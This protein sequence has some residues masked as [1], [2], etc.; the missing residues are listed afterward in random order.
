MDGKSVDKE[1]EAQT[2]DCSKGKDQNAAFLLAKL[3]S[4]DVAAFFF[5]Q[6]PDVTE[7]VLR[8]R[9]RW[10]H[11]YAGARKSRCSFLG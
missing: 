6:T 7:K 8:G 9:S 5:R 2:A 1:C 4:K 3:T 11:V 10:E